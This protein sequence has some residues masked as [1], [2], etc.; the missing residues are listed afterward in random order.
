MS[1]RYRTEMKSRK[2]NIQI[3]CSREGQAGDE[4]LGVISVGPLFK[5][6]ALDK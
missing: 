2:L 4:I 3:W 5:I 6:T 1:I